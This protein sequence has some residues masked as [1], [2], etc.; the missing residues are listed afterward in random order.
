MVFII[1]GEV[2]RGQVGMKSIFQFNFIIPSFQLC[3]W[4]MA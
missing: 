3:R 2:K 4:L 1:Q